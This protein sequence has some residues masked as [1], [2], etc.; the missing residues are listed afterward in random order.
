[1]TCVLV[2]GVPR[3]GTSCVAGV[4]HHLGIDMGDHARY[5]VNEMNAAGFFMDVGFQEIFD[6]LPFMPEP[7]Q[8][9]DSHR[10]KVD[11]RIAQRAAGGVPWGAKFTH[12]AF[13]AERFVGARIIATQRARAAS[14]ASWR[15]WDGEE[16][17]IDRAAFAVGA[18]LVSAGRRGAAKMIVD[19]DE[20][21]ARPGE[22]VGRIARFVDRPVR[23]EAVAFVRPELRRHT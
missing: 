14:I 20:L 23:P 8:V 16:H 4:L 22:I 19:Y 3:S 6:D 13:V 7:S 12:A 17:D 18:A 15:Q 21:L 11:A 2:F 9:T 10:A 1:M 5:P